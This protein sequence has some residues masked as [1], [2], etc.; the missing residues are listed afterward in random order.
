MQYLPD[1]LAP[2]LITL[3]GTLIMHIPAVVLFGW[4]GANFTDMVENPI[5]RWVFILQAVC[6]FG[7]RMFDEMDG[8]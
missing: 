4:Y 6:Y 1:W 3:I 2:N 5:P 7:Y 8:K